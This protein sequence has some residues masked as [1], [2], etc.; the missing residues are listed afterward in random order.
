MF[1]RVTILNVVR[2]R[3]E[4]VTGKFVIW[5]AL[6]FNLHSGFNNATVNENITK[7]DILHGT[8]FTILEFDRGLGGE[9]P[10]SETS[11][12][13]SATF[14]GFTTSSSHSEPWFT[15]F[16]PWFTSETSTTPLTSAFTGF[17][18]SSSHSEPWFTDFELTDSTR[19]STGNSTGSRGST[20]GSADST[21]GSADSTRGSTGGSTGSRGSS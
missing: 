5:I 8:G 7:F 14:T 21:G 6:I 15:D 12:T 9:T 11:T 18:T 17:T 20:G 4:N 19:G 2:S 1:I 3:Y 16:E 13:S 10:S